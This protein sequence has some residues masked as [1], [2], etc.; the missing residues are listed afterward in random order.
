MRIHKR[1]KKFRFKSDSTTYTWTHGS[2]EGIKLIYE[3]FNENHDV[4]KY[5]MW[6]DNSH[7]VNVFDQYDC[8]WCIEIEYIDDEPEMSLLEWVE[9]RR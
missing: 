8:G 3:Y 4:I 6:Y 9:K 7:R 2:E 1:I 5:T